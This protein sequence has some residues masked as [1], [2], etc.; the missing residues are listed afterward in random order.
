M[1]KRKIIEI[2]L[3]E[4]ENDEVDITFKKVEETEDANTVMK[5]LIQYFGG[6]Q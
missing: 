2:Y 6:G 1:S 4:K 3:E 5:M